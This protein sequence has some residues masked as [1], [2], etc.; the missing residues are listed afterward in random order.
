MSF[1]L[2][3]ASSCKLAAVLQ[4]AVHCSFQQMNMTT[5]DDSF[6]FCLPVVG[7]FLPF[8]YFAT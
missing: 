5:S 3:Y 6:H 4:T 2:W 7:E 8:N 1:V